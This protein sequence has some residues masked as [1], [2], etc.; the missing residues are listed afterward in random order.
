M[1]QVSPEL[2]NDGEVLCGADRL[3]LRS[4]GEPVQ[5]G[6]VESPGTVMAHIEGKESVEAPQGEL[7]PP[8]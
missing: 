6:S 5:D 4:T 8:V 7:C 2:P 1:P 3:A